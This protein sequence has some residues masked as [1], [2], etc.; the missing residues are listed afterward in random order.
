LHWV[1]IL[2]PP[3]IVILVSCFSL[4]LFFKAILELKWCVL[5]PVYLHL[6]S[7]LPHSCVSICLLYFHFC[8]EFLLSV[9]C[10]VWTLDV[11]PRP[12]CRR[13]VPYLIC[14]AIGRW[15]NL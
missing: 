1:N 13:L 5:S 3:T 7:C 12:I 11:P 10:I 2:W 4:S 8:T 14:E 6:A 15:W 9:G